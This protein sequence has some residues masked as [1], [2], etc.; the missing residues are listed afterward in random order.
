MQRQSQCMP[1]K[2]QGTT[3]GSGRLHACRTFSSVGQ[4]SS[5]QCWKQRRAQDEKGVAASPPHAGLSLGH[6][7]ACPLN[8]RHH[9]RRGCPGG[10]GGRRG[11]PPPRCL[12][13]GEPS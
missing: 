2:Q 13:S 11:A 1:T 12:L 3:G 5:S 6:Q 7:A 8:G 9:R 4:R 10:G